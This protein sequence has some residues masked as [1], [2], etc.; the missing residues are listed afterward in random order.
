MI[1]QFVGEMFDFYLEFIPLTS[2]V[3]IT[4]YGALIR[5]SF[6]QAKFF[7]SNASII[8]HSNNTNY[9]NKLN[10]QTHGIELLGGVSF[11]DFALYFG[12]YFFGK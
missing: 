6:F 4:N 12:C 5:W 3:G 2:N 8:I 1:L 10:T 7:P 9:K 11:E